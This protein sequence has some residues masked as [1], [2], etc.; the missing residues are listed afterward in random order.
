MKGIGIDLVNLNRIDL[1]NERFIRHILTEKEFACFLQLQTEKRK[2]EYLGGRFAGKEAYLKAHGLGLGAISF[3]DIEI[4][5]HES[6]APYLN[7]P[8]ALISISHDSDYATAIVYLNEEFE[9]E[10]SYLENPD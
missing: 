7:D 9:K 4:L 1:H 2:R 5:N 6:G 10:P 3:Q 8:H